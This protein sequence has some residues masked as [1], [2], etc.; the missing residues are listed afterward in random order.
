MF[1]VMTIKN[2]NDDVT[3]PVYRLNRGVNFDWWQSQPT[4]KAQYEQYRANRD[5]EVDL[6]VG[7]HEGW[8]YCM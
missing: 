6:C 3:Y 2:T 1:R 4:N 5:Q 7:K 8:L